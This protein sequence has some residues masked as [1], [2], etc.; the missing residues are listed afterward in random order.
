MAT[1]ELSKQAL[2]QA[3][4]E[5]SEHFSEHRRLELKLAESRYQDGDLLGEGGAK[6]VYLTVDRVTGRTLVRVYPK[7]EELEEDFLR[8]AMLH[9]HLEHPNI[10]PFYDIGLEDGRPFFCMKRIQG[11]TLE[12]Y[13]MSK[14]GFL[15]QPSTRNALLDAFLKVCDAVSYAHDHEVLHLDL[16]PANIQLSPYGEVLVGDW[17][18]A[19]ISEA[20]SVESDDEGEDSSEFSVAQCTG[21]FTRHGYLSGTPGFM[22]PEQCRKGVAKTVQADVYGLGAVLVFILTGKPPISGGEQQVVAATLAGQWSFSPEEI[23]LGLRAVVRKALA[24]DCDARYSNVEALQDDINAFR[25][26]Y[27]TSA[28]EYSSRRLLQSLYRRNKTTV[29]LLSVFL[30]ILLTVTVLFVRQLKVSENEA[31]V[32]ERRAVTER[33]K[34]EQAFGLLQKTQQEKQDQEQ[35]FARDY[36][37]E[38]IAYYK[39]GQR[40]RHNYFPSRDEKAY[41]LVHKALQTDSENQEAWALQGKLAMLTGRMDVARVSFERAGDAYSI[42][43]QVCVAYKDRNLK[44]VRVLGEMLWELLPSED[45]RLIHDF[46]FKTIFSKLPR[47]QMLYFIEESLNIRNTGARDRL[48]FVYDPERKSLDLSGNKQLVYIFMLKNLPLREIDLSHTSVSSDF[49][50]LEKMPLVR[51]DV[52][53]SGMNN[54][55]LKCLA[56]RP[57]RQLV[58]TGCKV[59]LLRALR[60]CP[61]EVLDIRHTQIKQFEQLQ[62]FPDL[63][64]VICTEEQQPLLRDA[65]IGQN[66]LEVKP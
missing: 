31:L 63:K 59:S 35:T 10:V 9:A 13:V 6:L 46:M 39:G 44:D 40:G 19:R 49:Y 56:G 41:Q 34:T 26:G 42:H 38:S 64:K 61:L 51:V 66:L 55:N 43:H 1:H 5:A 36:L 52:A 27:L 2:I 8:E 33:Q 62:A 11:E 17:G 24:V 18:L 16:K 47:E 57:I 32:A 58:L 22:A 37:R 54:Q 3:F 23:P 50:H 53:W 29:H 14:A 7:S 48:H 45:L 65:G 21:Q 12:K 30:L 60:D 28:E 25:A 4:Q 15:D 20:V